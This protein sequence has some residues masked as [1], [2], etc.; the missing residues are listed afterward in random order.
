M[1]LALS[2]S[3]AKSPPVTEMFPATAV[4]WV[5]L[6]CIETTPVPRPCTVPPVT[7]ALMA[8][9]PPLMACRVPLLV[10]AAPSR[11]RVLPLES[12]ETVALLVNGALN[13]AKAVDEVV[14]I[15]ESPAAVAL[16][17]GVG[18]GQQNRS[19]PAERGGLAAD[20][21]EIGVAAATVGLDDAGVVDRAFEEKL[22]AVEGQRPGVGEVV[23]DAVAVACDHAT[24]ARVQRA[25]GDRSSDEQGAAVGG[26][27]SPLPVLTEP[28]R[29]RVLPLESAET[30]ALL[31]NGA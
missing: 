28:S 20:P 11:R 15:E 9:I 12:A 18:L 8:R 14:L 23:E 29:M 2:T 5:R 7:L 3:G 4:G 24:I 19:S 22:G 13:L 27:V 25:A 30:V 26:H 16:D 10:L 6:P 21:I 1:L 31:V 17:D